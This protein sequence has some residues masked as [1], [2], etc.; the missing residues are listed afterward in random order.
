MTL[1]FPEFLSLTISFSKKSDE[2]PALRESMPIANG[3]VWPLSS[4][5]VLSKRS[6]KLSTTS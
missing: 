3:V 6:G 2:N 1:I 5:S 4:I